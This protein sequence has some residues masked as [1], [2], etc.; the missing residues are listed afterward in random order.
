[1]FLP[2]TIATFKLYP[3]LTTLMTMSNAKMLFRKK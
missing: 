1:M 2:N 3:K